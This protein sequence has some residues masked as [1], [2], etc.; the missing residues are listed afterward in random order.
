MYLL[1]RVRHIISWLPLPVIVICLILNSHQ[2]AIKVS[3]HY[4]DTVMTLALAEPEPEPQ[5]EPQP[6]PEPEPE[7]EPEPQPEPEPVPVVPQ[8]VAEVAPAP[9]PRPKPTPKST[10][11]PRPKPAVSSPKTAPVKAPTETRRSETARVPV[12]AAPRVNVQAIENGYIQ[13]LRVQ[14][15]RSKRYPTGRQVSLERP[16][17]I[18]E[19]WLEVDRSGRV[20]NSGINTRARSM[21]LNRAADSSL[22]SIKQVKPFPADA[23]AGQNTKRFLATFN[24]QPQ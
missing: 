1:Y 2:T 10:P 11:K 6:E 3:P 8:P 4:D 15:D 5:P 18:V 9:K 7:Q 14:L 22:Q 21:L 17:G 19:V 24:Y 16:E 20:I 23:F 12:P 13:A